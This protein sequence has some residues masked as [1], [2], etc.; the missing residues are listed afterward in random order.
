MI[1]TLKG[2]NFSQSN[3][4]TL[5]TY[6]IRFDSNGIT[7]TNTSVDKET[8]T[9]Y[10]ATI[11]FKENY[12]LDG[13]IT[14]TMGGTDITFTALS[15]L[16][17]NIAKVT[18][19]VVI[20]VPTKNTATGEEGGDNEEGGTTNYL[21]DLDFTQKSF[22]DYISDG[23]LG[24]VTGTLST[25]HTAE[26]DTFTSSG[27]SYVALGKSLTFPTNFEIQLRVKTSEYNHVAG[28]GLPLFTKAAARPWIFL[29][30]DYD[31]NTYDN[32]FGLQSR[33]VSTSGDVITIDDVTIPCNDNIFHDV[34]IHYEGNNV[35]MSVDGVKSKTATSTRDSNTVTHM[36]GYS[37]S[38]TMNKTTLAY[39]RVVAL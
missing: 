27:A 31:G 30:G 36:F 4:G 35:W 18:G 3:I 28:C 38:Y 14:I 29:R 12:E 20:T 2:A 5:S 33:L 11:T 16:N 15:G 19:N 13:S 17:I 34:I 10:T 8:N 7:N 21:F 25:T 32:S 23:T 37:E 26:G 6:S 39:I 1:I 9:G 24:T 22:A